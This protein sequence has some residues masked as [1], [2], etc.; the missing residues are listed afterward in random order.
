MNTI[1]LNLSGD[2]CIFRYSADFR[3]LYFYSRSFGWLPF[4][5]TAELPLRCGRM[6]KKC[7]VVLT[8]KHKLGIV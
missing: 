1:T 3:R 6:L 8:I 7:D 2:F 5:R 4:S